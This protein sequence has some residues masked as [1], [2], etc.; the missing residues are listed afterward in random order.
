MSRR[1][2]HLDAVLRNLGAVYYQSLR[3]SGSSAA[4]AQ[5]VESVADAGDR[6][7]PEPTRKDSNEPAS[8][9][10]RRPRLP[11]RRWRVRDVMTT[12][13][14]AVPKTA[15]YHEIARLMSERAVGAVPVLDDQR[16]VLGVV[17]EADLLPRQE[18]RFRRWGTGLPKRTRREIAQA[19]ARTAGQLMTAPPITIHPDAPL[20]AA[21]RQL[22]GHHIRRMPVVDSSG[23]LLGI[24]SRRDLLSVFLRPDDD[25]AADVRAVVTDILL[26][27]PGAVTVSV[28]DGMVK[29]AGSLSSP[30]LAP[31]AV[32]L[33]ADV[34]GAIGVIDKLDREP[35]GV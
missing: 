29:L 1:D 16:R 12:H 10:G 17:S 26:E 32:R 15:N 6:G 20:G 4:V 23:Q 31:A 8:A 18:S 14:A 22:N 35:L 27:D 34:D 11:G 33:A 28:H 9:G 7:G 3:G 24:V 19:T 2:A 13:V 25:I 21:A 30:E 5:A